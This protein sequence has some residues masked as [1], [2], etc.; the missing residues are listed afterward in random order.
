MRHSPPAS[1][2]L[3]FFGA[4]MPR[5]PPRIL[6]PCPRQKRLPDKKRRPLFRGVFFCFGSLRMSQR[7]RR[8]T[9]KSAKRPKRPAAAPGS[10]M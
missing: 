4:P 8:A 9:V 7:R 2:C 1:G 10:G 6:R 3:H 5:G